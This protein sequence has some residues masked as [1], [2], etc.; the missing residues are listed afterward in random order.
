MD[1]RRMLTTLLAGGTAAP[2]AMN[3]LIS[4]ALA[5]DGRTGLRGFRGDVTVNGKPARFGMKID[6]GD[7]VRTGPDAEAIYVIGRDAFMQRGASHVAFGSGA[8]A[9]LLRVITGRLLSVF[10]RGHRRIATPAATIGIRGTGCYIEAAEEKT[11][12]CLCYGEAVIMRTGDPS[13]TET[14]RTRHHD[15]PMW[16]RDQPG[17]EMMSAAGVINHTDTELTL[18]EALVDRTPPFAPTVG[19]PPD[20]SY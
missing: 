15:K 9:D 17:N 2:L 4:D 7:T 8:A 13:Q 18:L 1:R 20:R 10:A 14:V 19:W 3:T 12:F 6:S 16:L 5:R 11:Y